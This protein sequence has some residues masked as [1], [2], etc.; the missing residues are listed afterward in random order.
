M[1][2]LKNWRIVIHCIAA[3]SLLML[4]PIGI[5]A[6]DEEEEAAA[7]DPI[8]MRVQPQMMWTDD[9]IDQWIF[10][11]GRNAVQARKR[12]DTQLTLRIDELDRACG[13]TEIQKK[14]L[15]LAGQGDI[16]RLFDDMLVIRKKFDKLRNDQN[17][18]NQIFQEINPLQNRISA[19]IF[20]SE[21]F[22]Q[23]SVLKTLGP[24]QAA[25]LAELDLDRRTFRYHAK[26]LL[27]LTLLDVG[28]PMR[29]EQRQQL[30]KL[31]QEETRPPKRFGQFDYQV[32]L[33]QLSKLPEEKIKPIFDENQ[34]KAM[35][36]QF[37]QAKGMEL[38]LQQNGILDAGPEKPEAQKTLLEKLLPKKEKAAN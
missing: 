2:N 25:K 15:Y 29:D 7:N 13:L 26:I 11:S 6:Q 32:V 38:Y 31:L 37:Q 16:K 3:V 5:S 24:D 18:I 28:V 36:T 34:W 12:L 8:A 23:K 20:R 19:G 14:K 27:A 22:Y 35:G 9:T 4:E 33:L 1:F 21:S 10:G 30:V 17:A